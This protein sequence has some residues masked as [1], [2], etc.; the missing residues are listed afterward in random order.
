M[1]LETLIN[2]YGYASV[3]I[4]TFLEGETILV[5]AGFAAH[6]GYMHLP[7][8]I[9][10]AFAG[11]LLGDQLF[12]LLGRVYG[13]KLLS[14]YPSA[15]IR[16]AKVQ[17][18]LDRFR[19]PLILVFRFLYGFRSITPFVIGMSTVPIGR[20]IL[21]NAA[22]A[23]VWATTVGTGGYLF[24]SALEIFL[25]NLKH[26][27]TR[28]LLAICMIGVSIWVIHFSLRKK[29]KKIRGIAQTSIRQQRNNL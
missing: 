27:E 4:G 8:V 25:G 1:T 3:L 29:R 13:E 11:S 2:T 9:G 15:K 26:Y 7:W 17:R 6:R 24:G 28:I 23:A 10:A 16:A 20:F 19:T 14:R 5:L 22:G 21:L 18:M 12:F